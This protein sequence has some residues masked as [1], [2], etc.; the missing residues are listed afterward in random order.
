M[1]SG[2]RPPAVLITAAAITVATSTM[3]ATNP[4]VFRSGPGR[5]KDGEHEL[6]STLLAKICCNFG[7]QLGVE[8]PPPVLLRADEVIE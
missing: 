6:S 2:S 8:I 4:V 1:P 5:R 3:A 7:K